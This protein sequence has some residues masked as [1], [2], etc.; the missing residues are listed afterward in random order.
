MLLEELKFTTPKQKEL[1]KSI[2][3]DK[4][5]LLDNEIEKLY[6]QYFKP[7]DSRKIENLING[8]MEAE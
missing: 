7:A 2:V 3:E 1:F 6:E 5:R 4:R 8:K